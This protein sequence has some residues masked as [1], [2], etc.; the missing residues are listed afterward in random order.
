MEKRNHTEASLYIARTLELAECGIGWA[1]PN[2]LVG[3]VIVQDGEVIGE[4]FHQRY[5]EA[6][7]EVN[8]IQDARQ[9]GHD[10]LGATMYVS[11]EPCHH[12]G[13]TPPC[14]DAI[15][16]A[17]IQRV[18]YAVSDP[19]QHSCGGT[20][21]VLKAFGITTA[22]GP[23]VVGREL[24][25]KALYQNRIFLYWLKRG[26]P[27]VCVKVAVSHDGKITRSAGKKT[28]ISGLEAQQFTHL[29][30]QRFESILVGVNTVKIDDPQLTTRL[31]S[32]KIAPKDP[33]RIILDPDLQ[34]PT[35]ARALQDHNFL[36]IT[37]HPVSTHYPLASFRDQILVLPTH[38][39]Q[40]DLY[41]ILRAL[42]ERRI[43]SVLMEGGQYTLTS[44]FEAGVVQEWIFI[45]SKEDFGSGVDFIQLPEQ[46]TER[47]R[48]LRSEALGS[49][50]AEYYTPLV[51][52]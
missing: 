47:F 1:A 28:Q 21:A 38:D 41:D 3:C 16:A 15:K 51:N 8:T 7:A 37:T 22:S 13:K 20:D 46:F 26:L 18:V 42:A 10:L 39:G 49:D 11:L 27:Y 2:P 23:E 17:G 35:Q 25:E 14:T 5:G 6:H 43:T 40:F 36:L 30:R 45:R 44:F 24:Y 12:H 48:L 32:S 9:K 19:N 52:A 50:M 31:S 4:G 33:L 29:L 34:I